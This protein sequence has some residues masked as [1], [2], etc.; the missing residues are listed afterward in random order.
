MAL[1]ATLTDDFSTKDTT[2]W[3]WGGSAGVTTNGTET[4]ANLPSAGYGSSSNGSIVSGVSY[5]LTGSSVYVDLFQRSAPNATNNETTFDWGLHASATVSTGARLIFRYYRAVGGT[6]GFDAIYSTDGTTM[7]TVTGG[8]A[9]ARWLRIRADATNIYWETSSNETTWSIGAQITKA[10]FTPGITAMFM[11][12]IAS[13]SGTAYQISDINGG[14]AA[15][16]PPSVPTSV[17]ASLITD[18]TVQIN[19][20]APSSA[21]SSAVSAYRVAWGG[22]ESGDMASTDRSTANM[23]PGGLTGFS[24]G[25]NYTVSVYAF[26]AS[27]RSPAGNVTFTTTGTVSNNVSGMPSVALGAYHRTHLATA[28][29]DTN[30]TKFNFLLHSFAHGT[31]TGAVSSVDS[32]YAGIKADIDSLNATGRKVLLSIGGA[33]D[34]TILNSDTNAQNMVNSLVSIINTN[35]FK[36]ID[37]DLES[38]ATYTADSLRYVSAKLKQQYGQSFIITCAPGPNNATYTAFAAT[39][40]TGW[41]SASGAVSYT[42]VL[43]DAIMPQFY[44]WPSNDAQRQSDIV[45][46]VNRLINSGVPTSRIMIGG[47]HPWS[48]YLFYD[49]NGNPSGNGTGG[50]APSVYLAAYNTLKA[51][52]K[53]PR[54]VF[55]WDSGH[56]Q[57]PNGYSRAAATGYAADSGSWTFRDTMF[58]G[59]GP[60]TAP[61]V[62]ITTPG[63]VTNLSSTR[64]AGGTTATATWGVPASDGG[65]AIDAYRVSWTS[66][67]STTVASTS[68]SSPFSLTGLPTAA[69]TVTVEAHNS[70]GY[71]P[72]TSVTM[73]AVSALPLIGTLSDNFDG[74]QSPTRVFD[75]GVVQRN[76]EIEFDVLD[77]T[78]RGTYVR[79]DMRA[80]SAFYQ[81]SP[82]TATNV[83]TAFFVRSSN[84]PSTQSIRI[85]HLNGVLVSR[86]DNGTPDNSPGANTYNATSMKFWRVV[87][88]GTTVSLQTSPDGSTWTSLA[89]TGFA[90]PGWFSDV[91]VG[92][93]IYTGT[94]V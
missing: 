51:Q 18:T 14:G 85:A 72:A 8:I 63:A 92:V 84:A 87:D 35:G 67:G 42:G 3:T 7:N 60:S 48:S 4:V 62:T 41:T 79:G 23:F 86:F 20:G 57:N 65:A 21:G 55:I 68:A 39:P 93:E 9:D 91:Q 58:T 44:D 71:G 34:S 73:T 66:G 32:L 94:T 53:Q 16:T 31:G 59:I 10:T 5:D 52:G 46:E 37:F 76:G 74:V 50:N 43:C 26:N 81:M 90:T 30:L 69:V 75:S 56:D 61:V 36:G 1:F 70:V 47:G 33:G 54:G 22:W 78:H 12:A 11:Q 19:W 88:N 80:Q 64:G 24:P 89:R 40:T 6:G 15:G 77:A 2:K 45:T 28:Y 29:T 25:T 17:T 83:V 49:A 38:A 82:N 13:G 27:G